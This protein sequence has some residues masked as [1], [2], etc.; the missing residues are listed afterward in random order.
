[1]K[2]NRIAYK[3]GFAG[4]VGIALSLTMSGNQMISETAVNLGNDRADAQQSIARHALE[5]DVGLR[6]MQLSVRDIRLAKTAAEAEKGIANLRE[7][8]ALSGRELDAAIS[9]TAASENKGRLETVKTVAAEYY[10]LAEEI[11]K[12]QL[13]SL[14]V[15]EMRT[16][17][18]GEWRRAM[19]SAQSQLGTLDATRRSD[20]EKVLYA[21]DATF[22]ML[23]AATWRFGATDEPEQKEIIEKLPGD[24]NAQLMRLRRL[25]SD[26]EFIGDVDFMNSILTGYYDASAEGVAAE[27]ARK[28]L[29][30]VKAMPLGN[31]ALDLMRTAVDASE[32]LA[33]EAKSR[34]KADLSSANQVN[35]GL[36]ILVMLS[37][38]VS[39]VFGF[40]SVSRPLMKLN[41]AL[42]QMASGELNVE[43]PGAQR[44]DEVGDIAKTVVVIRENAAHR[45]QQEAEAMAD[46]EHAA[47]ER[48]KQDMHRLADEFEGAVG[49]IV[50]TVSSASA[51]L[52]ANAGTLTATAEQTERL[53]TV[54]AAASEQASTNVQTVA[55]ATEEMAS[56]I[57]EISRQVQDSARIAGSAVQQAQNTNQ[58]INQLAQAASRIGDVVELINTIAGQTNLLALNA[59]IE[60]ARAGEAGRGFAV[61]ASEVKA[62]A[63]QTA[64]ATGEISQQIT[65]MQSATKESVAAIHEIGTTISQMSEISSAIASAVEQQGAATQEISRNVQQAALGTTEV[66]SNI[67]DVQRGASETGSASSQVLV[68]AQSLS[69]DS[70]DLKREVSRFLDSV[71]AA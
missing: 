20:I 23:E 44:G 12:T 62:L 37:S 39:V 45:A 61:V 5:A 69:R 14:E 68:A 28:N 33:D 13:K 43:I 6:R 70:D 32:T 54:V 38:V 53:T 29:V 7:A 19:E 30:D 17:I 3:L 35:F 18:I 65:G 4:L 51:E 36:G 15:V 24:L 22:N 46:Q 25:N 60:A 21:T 40:A 11:A 16:V 26:P 55:S 9:Q 50:Q 59:T 31:R 49:K 52:E 63:E 56:S 2:L 64:K 58:R 67:A 47:T 42:G 34:A 1:M 41:G 27:V 48:R 66:S 71:R 57:N 10:R 8:N